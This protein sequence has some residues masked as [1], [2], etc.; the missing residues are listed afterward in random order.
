MS[1]KFTKDVEDVGKGLAD[2][3]ADTV[4]VVGHGVAGTAKGIADGVESVSAHD[5]LKKEEHGGS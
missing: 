3:V 4:N 1:E 5:Q 2:T